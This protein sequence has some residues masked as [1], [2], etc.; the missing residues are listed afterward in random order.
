MQQEKKQHSLTHGLIKFAPM[1]I[2]QPWHQIIR[3]FFLQI[4]MAFLGITAHLRDIQ[5]QE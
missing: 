1:T 4:L 5:Q 2:Q 3:A